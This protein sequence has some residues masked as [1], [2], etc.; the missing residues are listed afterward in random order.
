MRYRSQ[1]FRKSDLSLQDARH[2]Y[3]LIR[4]CLGDVKNLDVNDNLDVKTWMLESASC[5]VHVLRREE[6]V[7]RSCEELW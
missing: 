7:V 2:M 3:I 1:F 5:T 4:L 6:R